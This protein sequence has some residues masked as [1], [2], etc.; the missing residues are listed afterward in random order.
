M[1]DTA[2]AYYNEDQ[3]GRAIKDSGVDR[4]EIFLI[5]KLWWNSMEPEYV[6]GSLQQC[7]ENLGVDYIDLVLLHCPGIPPE[8]GQEQDGIKNAE[9]RQSGW[10]ALEEYYAKGKIKAIG[11]SK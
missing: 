5:T 2:Q 1:I 10:K 3:V 4:S 8:G 6:M 7:F 9:F 11:V